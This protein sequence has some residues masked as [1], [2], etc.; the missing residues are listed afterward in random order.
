MTVTEIKNAVMNGKT[1]Y[2]CNPDY[3]VICD[4]HGQWLI[5]CQS[6]GY[7]IGLTW[8]DEITL[9]DKEENFYISDEPV[10]KPTVI[11]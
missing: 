4:K 10:K 11:L 5:K 6:N 8:T 3:I 7:C 1:V 2:R 9:N